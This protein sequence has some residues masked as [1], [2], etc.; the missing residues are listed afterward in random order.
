MLKTLKRIL[1][2]R[3]KSE[4]S[5]PAQL[6]VERLES[7]EVLSAA[8]FNVASAIVNSPENFT[9]F[10]RNEFN[11]LLLRAP[12]IQGLDFF[13]T[14]LNQGMS[15][16]AVE[17]AFV[18]SPEFI[19]NHGNTAIGWLNGV[20]NDLLGRAPDQVGLN[21][22]LTR[23]QAGETTFQIASEITTSIE[24]ESIVIRQD[25]I[26]FLG[27]VPDT[28][29]LNHWLTLVQSGFTR[30]FVAS[31]IVGSNEFFRIQGNT[32]VAFVVAAFNDVLGRTPDSSELT[33]FLSQLPM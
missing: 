8:T 13:V 31:G 30:A 5:K 18:S 20:Y 9:D 14:R 32:N 22:W 3:Q 27:R 12:D 33:F 7:R 21:H 29:G 25:Y 19:F 16:E 11:S 15:P 24:R 6:A 10:V 26:S 28:S 17:A 2:R 1:A 23:L 4:F